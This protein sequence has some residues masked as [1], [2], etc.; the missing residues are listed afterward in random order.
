MKRSAHDRFAD[1]WEGLKIVLLGI[2]RGEARL[3]LPALGGLFDADQ[4]PDL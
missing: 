3:A 1:L 2:A 4:C